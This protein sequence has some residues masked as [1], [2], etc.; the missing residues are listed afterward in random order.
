MPMKL[1]HYDNIGGAR[2]IT[3][4]TH[5]NIPILKSNLFK[6]YVLDSIVNVRNIFKFKLTGYVLMP[7]HVHLVILPEPGSRVGEI[8][9]IIKRDSAKRMMLKLREMNS[10]ILT[11][12]KVIRNQLE[13]YAIWQRRCYDHNC[14]NEEIVWEK[15]NYCHNNPEKRGLV[16]SPDEW[17]WSSYRNYHNL[18]DLK[19]EIDRFG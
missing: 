11:K 9:G 2:F 17:L 6:Q 19:I 12:L 1:K 3:F 7:D 16:K 4:G 13:K 8:V 10:P 14:R 18:G 15:I 5:R